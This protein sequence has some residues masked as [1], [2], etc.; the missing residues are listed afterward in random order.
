MEEAHGNWA[1]RVWQQSKGGTTRE[2]QVPLPSAC[3]SG[4]Q[5]VNQKVNLGGLR[6]RTDSLD[7]SAEMVPRSFL[8][9]R[10]ARAR[11]GFESGQER[12]YSA[13]LTQRPGLGTR[14]M[15]SGRRA[16]LMVSNQAL[17][18]TQSGMVRRIKKSPAGPFSVLGRRPAAI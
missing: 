6:I 15:E 4:S 1:Y 3:G 16:I 8:S 14:E 9:L 13:E 17:L 10:R 12:Q 18:Q 11:Q 2:G 7:C 5:G